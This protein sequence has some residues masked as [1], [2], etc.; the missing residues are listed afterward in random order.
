MKFGK[1]V[2]GSDHSLPRIILTVFLIMYDHF[3]VENH[4]G[5]LKKFL[6]PTSDPLRTALGAVFRLKILFF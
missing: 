2:Y 4:L 6:T 3:G 5:G 1:C